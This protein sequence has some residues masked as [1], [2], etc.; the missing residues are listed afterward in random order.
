MPS[1][2]G[3]SFTLASSASIMLRARLKS[4][5]SIAVMT[6]FASMQETS[7]TA[8]RFSGVMPAWMAMMPESLPWLDPAPTP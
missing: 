4:R 1:W 6:R 3:R 2:N 8:A 7:S 5:G